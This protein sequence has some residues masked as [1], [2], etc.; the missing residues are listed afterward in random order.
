MS[1]D[2]LPSLSHGE[3]F[4]KGMVCYKMDRAKGQIPKIERI[5]V[6]V[7]TINYLTCDTASPHTWELGMVWLT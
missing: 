2:T 5:L 4:P 3:Y 1:C 7:F 6:P